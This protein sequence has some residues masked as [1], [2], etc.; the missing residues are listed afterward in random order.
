MVIVA[1]LQA[2]ANR[3]AA[4]YVLTESVVYCEGYD[5]GGLPVTAQTTVTFPYSYV[6]PAMNVEVD[7]SDNIIFHQFPAG[8]KVRTE[9]I[10]HDLTTRC[11]RLHAVRALHDCA[12][13]TRARS[14]FLRASSPRGSG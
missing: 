6:G 14:L 4:E 1:C 13:R 5:M 8:A 9:V 12:A 2:V 7:W 11:C 10:L 3:T